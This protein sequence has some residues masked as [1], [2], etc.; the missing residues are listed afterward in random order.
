MKFPDEVYTNKN[1]DKSVINKPYGKAGIKQ[2]F[3]NCKKYEGI[4]QC[5]EHMKS[6]FYD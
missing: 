2:R 6:G 4:R 5:Y 1:G 3:I